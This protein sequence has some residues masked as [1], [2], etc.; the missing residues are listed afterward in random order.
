M[1]IKV[2]YL[3]VYFSMSILVLFNIA[4]PITLICISFLLIF[5]QRAVYLYFNFYFI[6]LIS[7]FLFFISLCLSRSFHPFLL[8]SFILPILCSPL[9]LI[10]ELSAKNIFHT[11][12]SLETNFI[13]Y[14]LAAYFALAVGRTY[15]P[16]PYS[17]S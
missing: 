9:F 15:Y 2:M 17:S 11:C 12:S 10:S 7:Y 8:S 1:S 6:E 14:F 5:F 3:L 4:V 13:F 16:Q